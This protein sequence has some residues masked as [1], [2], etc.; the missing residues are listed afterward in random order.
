MNTPFPAWWKRPLRG[1]KGWSSAAAAALAVALVSGVIGH[2][3]WPAP[4]KVILTFQDWVL[5]SLFATACGFASYFVLRWLLH[6]KRLR[7]LFFA[8]ACMLTLAM[9][10]FVVENWR[11]HLAWQRAQALAEARGFLLDY[12][13][14][15]P[16]A[17]PDEVNM[18]MAPFFE[19]DRLTM[20]ATNLRDLPSGAAKH[21]FVLE[22]ISPTTR[23]APGFGSWQLG[24][25]LPLEAWAALCLS[26]RLPIQVQ[27]WLRE[28]GVTS[29]QAWQ[30]SLRQ[31]HGSSAAIVAEMLRAY[32]A[33]VAA[34]VEATRRPQCRFPIR[35]EWGPEARLP[36]LNTL[37]KAADLLTLRACVRLELGEGSTAHEEVLAGLRLIQAMETEPILL[38][39]LVRQRSCERL[40][41]AVWEGLLAGR[42]DERQLAELEQVLEKIEFLRELPR[43]LQAE[44][45]LALWTLRG[46]S[47]GTYAP[48]EV[49][50]Q[51]FPF[52]WPRWPWW[53]PHGW[54][55]QNKANLVRYYLDRVAPVIDP[56]QCTV[57]KAAAQQ[58]EA[59]WSKHSSD[60]GEGQTL[61]RT[62]PYN[63][64]AVGLAASIPVQRLAFGQS[65]VDLAR[66]ACR[67]ERF[68]IRTGQLPDELKDLTDEGP[69]PPDRITGQSLRYRKLSDTKYQLYATGWDGR[70]DGGVRPSTPLQPTRFHPSRAADW[71][72]RTADD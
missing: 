71:I 36:H 12:K 8:L 18:A 20:T 64:L 37:S 38:S 68:R 67:I 13:A 58:L 54:A 39:L 55:D 63:F 32:D 7:A 61:R 42:W 41:Q 52:D 23:N 19:P 11:G 14:H 47:S 4:P 1:W 59:Y 5:S 43:V 10:A 22:P 29:V 34:F 66:V 2:R 15:I 57:R 44:C 40:L 50:G 3:L 28:Q 27:E 46:I 24:Q 62:G 69:L 56:E 51:E 31:K 17:I 26:N 35:Y 70:D 45:A 48:K 30:A 72:W 6:P 53:L 33:P 25:R 49:V 65:A 16:P 21:Y 60:D 9:L